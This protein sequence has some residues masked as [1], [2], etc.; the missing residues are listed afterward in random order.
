MR[1][2]KP[3]PW[4]RFTWSPSQL[5]AGPSLVKK[6]LCLNMYLSFLVLF[7]FL[8]WQIL[9]L[10]PK[11]SALF[12]VLPLHWMWKEET[13]YRLK[14]LP[15]QKECTALLKS[16]W[17]VSNRLLRSPCHIRCGGHSGQAGRPECSHQNISDSRRERFYTRPGRGVSGQTLNAVEV[18]SVKF[19]VKYIPACIASRF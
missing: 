15:E 13:T 1:T 9:H 10:A 18:P 5:V 4:K 17:S 8:C 3:A 11:S 14:T 6:L 19:H 7:W 16:P 12:S 2:W